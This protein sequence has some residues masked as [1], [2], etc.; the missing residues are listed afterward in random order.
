M[1][2]LACKCSKA[3][4]KLLGTVLRMLRRNTVVITEVPSALLH[5]IAQKHQAAH[6]QDRR[7]HLCRT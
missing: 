2:Q 7:F 6:H 1:S 3:M 4:T 5:S